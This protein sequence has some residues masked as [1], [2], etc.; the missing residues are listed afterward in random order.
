MG[1]SHRDKITKIVSLSPI[2]VNLTVLYTE[3]GNVIYESVVFYAPK[4]KPLYHHGFHFAFC[5]DDWEI[6]LYAQQ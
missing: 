2:L 6:N 5:T 4:W 3:R 1:N